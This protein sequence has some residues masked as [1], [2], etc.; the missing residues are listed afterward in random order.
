M[1]HI[2]FSYSQNCHKHTCMLTV[3]RHVF[4]LKILFYT[5][6]V[7]NQNFFDF[8]LLK[9]N[10]W[11]FFISQWIC[12][13]LLLPKTHYRSLSNQ[14]LRNMRILFL[15]QIRSKMRNLDLKKSSFTSM[16][17]V[18]FFLFHS[19]RFELCKH[20]FTNFPFL[21]LATLKICILLYLQNLPKKA[22]FD[23]FALEQKTPNYVSLR[24]S[25]Q[26]HLAQNGRVTNERLVGI[27]Y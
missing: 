25:Y 5:K 3:K 22:W 20:F 1:W 9:N 26:K 27:C 13:W 14:S 17:Q 11:W 21:T 24:S 23:T 18:S 7:N 15:H 19:R 8:L 4:T 10:V 2:F 16:C 12:I 6:D